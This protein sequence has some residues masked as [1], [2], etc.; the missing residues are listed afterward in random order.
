M[1]EILI[2]PLSDSDSYYYRNDKAFDL[3]CRVIFVAPSH[4]GKSVLIENI[5]SNPSFDYYDIFEKNRNVFIMSPTYKSGSM[6]I[7]G[8]PDE[9]IRDHLD[10]VLLSKIQDEQE[11]NIKD[12]GREKT[13][14]VAII[15]DDLVAG[16]TS[17]DKNVL[18]SLYFHGRHSKISTFMTSQAYRSIPKS[19]RINAD[20]TIIFSVNNKKELQSI[21][22]EQNVDEGAF[23]WILERATEEPYSFLKINHKKPLNERYSVRMSNQHFKIK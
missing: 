23:M 14:N 10:I 2:K 9:N 5:F 4:S 7:K 13:P 12:Y 20:H 16:L 22:E 1:S 18:R 8:V 6:K 17:H 11:E 19:V 3:P 21:C 15:I